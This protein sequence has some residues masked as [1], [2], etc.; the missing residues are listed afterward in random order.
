MSSCA[1]LCIFDSY[2]FGAC[3]RRGVYIYDLEV[4]GNYERYYSRGGLGF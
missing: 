4:G 3:T 1:L 2:D